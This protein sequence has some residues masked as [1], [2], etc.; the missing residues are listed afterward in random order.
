MLTLSHTKN[1]IIFDYFDHVL[2]KELIIFYLTLNIIPLHKKVSTK[3]VNN[4]RG[5]TLIS[6]LAKLFTSIQN[7]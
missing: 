5:I 6:C 2:D 4:Y 3:D 7:R 1:P